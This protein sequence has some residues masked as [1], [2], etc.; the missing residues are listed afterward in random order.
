[1]CSGNSP[2]MHD[3]VEQ[4]Q[5]WNP[6]APPGE[7]NHEA[8]YPDTTLDPSSIIGLIRR[9]LPHTPLSTVRQQGVDGAAAAMSLED[10]GTSNCDGTASAAATDAQSRETEGESGEP[11]ISAAEEREQDMIEAGCVLW[12][13]TTSAEQAKFL[14]DNFLVDVV[15]GVLQ[16]CH[17]PRL[18]EISL[19]I[20]ANL[21]CFVDT[22]DP[23]GS[24]KTREATNSPPYAPDGEPPTQGK[25]V[26]ERGQASGSREARLSIRDE[27]EDDG[28]G[29]RVTHGGRGEDV[30][31]ERTG[32]LAQLRPPP[33]AMVELVVNRFLFVE[34]AACVTEA[35]RVLA[36]ALRLKDEL[37]VG[38]WLAAM[39]GQGAAVPAASQREEEDESE[40]ESRGGKR[41]K[42]KER[43]RGE[44][45]EEAGKEVKE[46]A[47]EEGT[48]VVMRQLLWI[49]SNALSPL[50]IE[51]VLDLLLSIAVNKAAA[52]ALLPCLL[53]LGILECLLE[54]LPQGPGTGYHPGLPGEEPGD[55][56]SGSSK[57]R[58]AIDTA[59]RIIEALAVTDVSAPYVAAMVA[60]L[61]RSLR[62]VLLQPWEDSAEDAPADLTSAA[63]VIAL[64]LSDAT[65]APSETVLAL[66][67]DP[68]VLQ[69]TLALLRSAN[70]DEA[71]AAADLL[72][73]SARILI[74][75][76]TLAGGRPDGDP[77]APC[78]GG[79]RPQVFPQRSGGDDGYSPGGPQGRPGSPDVPAA[80]SGFASVAP[81]GRILASPTGAP[82]DEN[83]IDGLPPGLEILKGGQE[84][85]SGRAGGVEV[86]GRMDPVVRCLSEPR[87]VELL[88]RRVDAGGR[89]QYDGD[90]EEMGGSTRAAQGR[91][92][93]DEGEND[94]W[95][96][97]ESSWSEEDRARVGG[98][99]ADAVGRRHVVTR[100]CVW[101]CA[102][103]ESGQL[104]V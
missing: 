99:L 98:L 20:I 85:H 61:L 68:V 93:W 104:V 15:V 73:A 49:A 55:A 34:D 63:I 71:T 102:C 41:E 51:K 64:L 47:G 96:G 100:A 44:G 43:N 57:S 89:G 84:I 97:D 46:E 52:Q 65:E 4:E 18:H 24:S 32:T 53:R 76:L 21:L 3:L 74:R 91:K 7:E 23:P 67:A 70:A 36:T 90:W 45:G 1:M 33:W 59:I 103:V 39:E 62:V 88:L 101:T 27:E 10:V 66:A 94:G 92:G 5:L 40:D 82:A 19:G 48:N 58:T 31:G 25:P 87:G 14:V 35:C 6:A 22:G 86:W 95:E 83:G 50:L 69:R 2:S 81:S 80:S 11:S 72:L 75:S 13:L 30:A 29:A 38:P 9:L 42:V 54:H 60:P 37:A 77:G 16:S 28:R 79:S 8:F 12:D 26:K 78:A 56:Y 17:S